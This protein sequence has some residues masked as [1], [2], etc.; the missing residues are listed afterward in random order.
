MDDLL[1]G[2]QA[3]SEGDIAVAQGYFARVVKVNPSNSQAWLWLG[4]CIRDPEKKQ[5]CY[6]RAYQ[7]DPQNPEILSTVNLKNRN[8]PPR[9]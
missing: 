4:H 2:L 1:A 7:L 8:L 3:F 5:F 6:Q 9:E